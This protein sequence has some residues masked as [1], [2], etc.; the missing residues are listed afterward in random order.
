MDIYLLGLVAIALLV[1]IL[2]IVY[3]T[4]KVNGLE[5][6]TLSMASRLQDA[7]QQT[8]TAQ[9]PFSGMSGQ[10]LWDALCGNPPGNIDEAR[11]EEVRQ[12]YEPVLLKHIQSLFE[13]GR[14]D[15]QMGASGSPKNKQKINVLRG[16]VES[17]LPQEACNAIYQCG[18]DSV[19]KSEAEA[20]IVRITLDDVCASLFAKTGIELRHSISDQLMP[21]PEPPAQA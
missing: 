3:L 11:L 6:E 17:W 16:S 4:S 18:M 2:L 19:V 5:K 9:G 10:T 14:V 13:E 20:E 8:A 1:I 15:G 21:Q 12:R 7:A